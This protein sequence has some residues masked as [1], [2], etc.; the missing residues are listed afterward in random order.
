M[1]ESSIVF[2]LPEISDPD[3]DLWSVR[4]DL[5]EAIVFASF[6]NNSLSL[7]PKISSARKNP[8]SISIRLTDN[9]QAPKSS[10]YSL[11]IMVPPPA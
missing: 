2:N 7:E 11:S 1:P 9:N 10:L 3:G 6:S 5:G 8:Y 4:V